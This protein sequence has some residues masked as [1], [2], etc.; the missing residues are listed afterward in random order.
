VRSAFGPKADIGR[1][2]ELG[3]AI[4]PI[5]NDS[6]FPRGPAAN[7]AVA[8][9]LG[10]GKVPMLDLGRREFITLLGGAAIGCPLAAR[11]Q[12][13]TMPVI[14]FLGSS[15]A[16]EWGPFVA[17]F[18]RGLK[19]TGYVEGGN[20]TIE[21][22]WADGQYDRLP[23][24]AADLVRRQVAV[25]L[26]A[27]SPAPALAAKAATA[28]IPIVFS[29]GVDPVQFGL[30]A[31]LN[32]PAGN[33]TG[34]NFLVGH[35]AEKAL[36]LIHELIPNV[37]VGA[38]FVNPN[39]PNADSVTRNARETARSLGLQI[40][41]LNAGTASEI[42]AAFASLVEQRIGMLLS[43]ADPFFLG[44]RDQVVALA[45]RHAVPAI[46]FAREFVSAGGLMSYG[47]SIS[48]AYRRAGVYTGKVLK[49]VKPADLPVEQSTRFEFVINLKT[50]KILGLTIPDK[51]LALA[52]EVIE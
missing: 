20:V 10:G 33:I 39:N 6:D 25:I 23:A 38:M 36:G 30:V 8:Y 2:A 44:R 18:H 21:Y 9:R 45:A 4:T 26:A 19:E 48:D 46:Y 42:D 13:P 17:A 27:G 49:G 40:H 50:A 5:Q 31:S 24:L 1:W 15:S 29:L 35:L 51:L 16:A 11:A 14:G 43:G 52:D 32:R 28:T 47:T 37:A 12:Q 3:N 22:R 41:I 7:I 34:V